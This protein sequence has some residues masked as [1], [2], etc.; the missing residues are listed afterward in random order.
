[1]RLFGWMIGADGVPNAARRKW[2]ADWATAVAARDAHAAAALRARLGSEFAS[3][4]D[5]ELEQEMLDGLDGLTSLVTNLQRGSL[6]SVETT[7]RVVAHEVCHFSAP[8]SLVDVA[9]SPSGRLLLTRSRAVL[10]GAGAV[11]T[12]PLHAIARVVEHERDV[13]VGRSDV[14]A[15]YR[16]RFNTYADALSAAAL[17]RHLTQ[18][19]PRNC[20]AQL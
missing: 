2:R 19:D 12:I 16:F 3:D 6:P 10:V 8:A 5:V 13:L 4:D 14:D 11:T 17:L 9:G 18:R 1:M 15:V 7:H 20:S